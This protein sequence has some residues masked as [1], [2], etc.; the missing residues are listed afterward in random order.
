M[1]VSPASQSQGTGLDYFTSWYLF[2]SAVDKPAISQ[3]YNPLIL[4]RTSH[5]RELGDVQ[6]QPGV[7]GGRHAS[8]C[9]GIWSPGGFH[10]SAYSGIHQPGVPGGRPALLDLPRNLVLRRLSCLNLLGDPLVQ[11]YQEVK[12]PRPARGFDL[13][14]AVTPQPA[15][16]SAP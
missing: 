5:A 11:E 15:L 6:L 10:A 13:Q 8:V 12:M 4:P 3:D 2:P 16:G 1:A 7:P 9:L 14:E